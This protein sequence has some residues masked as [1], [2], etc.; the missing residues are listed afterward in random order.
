MNNLIFKVGMQFRDICIPNFSSHN[1]KSHF[2]LLD[3]GTQCSL[4]PHKSSLVFGYPPHWAKLSPPQNT[5]KWVWRFS[6]DLKILARFLFYLLQL[7]ARTG[8]QTAS[9][10]EASNHRL[11]RVHIT[12]MITLWSEYTLVSERCFL[13][14]FCIAL[15]RVSPVPWGRTPPTLVRVGV[16][17]RSP[18]WCCAETL[19][20]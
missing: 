14:L 6:V 8:N 3:I 2:Q 5:G 15:C 1:S 12:K 16:G 19:L 11:S 10:F 17:G 18:L 4:S 13:F 9:F 20:V 7:C